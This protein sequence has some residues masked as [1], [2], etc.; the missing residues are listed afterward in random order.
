MR[1]AP[2]ESLLTWLTI[3]TGP[4]LVEAVLTSKSHTALAI[5]VTPEELYNSYAP[6]VGLGLVYKVPYIK[7]ASFSKAFFYLK[8]ASEAE[9]DKRITNSRLMFVRINKASKVIPLPYIQPLFLDVP[10]TSDITDFNKPQSPRAFRAFRLHRVIYTE[11]STLTTQVAYPHLGGK[12]KSHLLNFQK[13]QLI[14]EL[15]EHSMVSAALAE[16]DDGHWNVT[17]D[18]IYPACLE[19]FRRRHE[20]SQA[21]QA[22]KSAE[23]S[24]TG[25]GSPTCAMTPPSATSSQPLFTP[26]LGAHEVRG[27][28]RDTLDQVY[29]LC[30]ETLQEMG[31]IWEVDRALA[32]SI[33]VVFLRLQLIVGDD[34]NTSL[35][36]LHADLEATTAELVR[37]MDI[38][39][40]NSTALPF[41]NPAIRVV[42]HRFTDLVRLKLALPLAQVDTAREDMERFLHHRL[43]ELRSQTDM[44]NLI[45]SLSQRVATHQ[46][47]VHQIVYSEPLENIEV[48]LQVLLGVA[49]DQP[50]ESNFFP[51]ILEGLLGRLS[52]AAPG[53]KNPP[54][55]AKEGVARLWASA[56]LDAVQKTEKRH[57]R[58]ETSGSSGMPSGLHLNYE[59]D[60]L[61][62]RSHQV[63]GV[64]TDP[65]F[66]PN[67]VNSVY[68]LVMPPVLSG[69]PPFTAAKDCPTI[70]LE[71]GDDRDSAVPPSPSPSTVGAP[72]A[73]K[74]KAGLPATPIQ[75]IGESDTESD[76][77]EN[78]EPEVD[79]SYSAQV[80]PPKSDRALRKQTHGK[81]DSVRDSKDGA[82]SPKRATIK[83]EMEVDANKSSSS[84]GLSDETFRDH[85]FTVYGRDS[86]A[87]HE[88]RAKIL[89]LEA[90]TRPS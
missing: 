74:S 46:S 20:S 66:L 73:E 54:T 44:K 10:T 26:T 17:N 28:V 30:L 13:Q 48:L 56:V 5:L 86:T 40:Q 25:G 67:M 35:R 9:A 69:A 11:G 27:I 76:K 57:V 62:Y 84:T 88:V 37:D 45:D 52:I 77:T 78:L 4:H 42:L 39:A 60:F 23:R 81:T 33:M 50:M 43:E 21:S 70:P 32:K 38:A 64:F 16:A 85:R 22:N 72:T 6:R 8:S 63:P 1:V 65:L 87:V 2:A 3:P 53:E 31:F 29:A 12:T 47:R 82:P 80:F 24:G 61:N 55:S 15:R 71:S 41:K 75:I 18:P 51:G 19:G 59:E 79:S 36:A 89:G 68:K 90:E 58:L 7:M 83:K 49:A 14:P 34:L